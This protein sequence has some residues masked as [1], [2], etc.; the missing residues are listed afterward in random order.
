M[1]IGPDKQGW[2]YLNDLNVR[3]REDTSKVQGDSAIALFG[4]ATTAG[5]IR[6]QRR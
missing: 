3:T 5:G 6:L 1:R 2:E 4:F